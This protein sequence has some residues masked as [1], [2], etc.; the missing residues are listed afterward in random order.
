MAQEQDHH[1]EADVERALKRKTQDG[2][3]FE[4]EDELPESDFEGFAEE[5][6]EMSEEDPK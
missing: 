4:S 6:V 3:G 2:S 5:D 1:D